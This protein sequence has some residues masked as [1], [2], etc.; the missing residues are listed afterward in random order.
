VSDRLAGWTELALD[1]AQQGF[2]FANLDA[3]LFAL[4]NV[5]VDKGFHQ[6]LSG[7][8]LFEEA[9]DLGLVESLGTLNMIAQQG[10]EN[11]QRGGV[12]A[13]LGDQFKQLAEALDGLVAVDVAQRE[14]HQSRQHLALDLAL[15]LAEMSC[16][17]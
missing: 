3:T 2:G 7:E 4:C 17:A 1:Q 12:A 14:L 8:G 11:I 9:T 16:S 13:D 10:F 5:P 15:L 6:R